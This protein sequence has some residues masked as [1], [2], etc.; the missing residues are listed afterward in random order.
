M[1][2]VPPASH[3]YEYNALQRGLNSFH[4]YSIISSVNGFSAE[5]LTNLSLSDFSGT[6][7][8]VSCFNLHTSV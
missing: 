4:T 7:S 8:I 1:S 3:K 5:I 2:H 6:R